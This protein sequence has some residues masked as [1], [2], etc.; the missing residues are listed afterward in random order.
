MIKNIF[1]IATIALLTGC[2]GSSSSTDSKIETKSIPTTSNY[3]IAKDTLVHDLTKDFNGYQ[4]KVL[5]DKTIGEDETS[6][7]FIS[8]YGKIN[9]KIQML[10]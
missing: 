5:T 7:D 9:A 6:N 1:I 10:F 4:L 2:G 8:V 3:H